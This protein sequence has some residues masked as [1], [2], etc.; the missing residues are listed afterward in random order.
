MNN[1]YLVFVITNVVLAII[2][3]IWFTNLCIRIYYDPDLFYSFL[4]W[5]QFIVSGY[6]LACSLEITIN[7]IIGKL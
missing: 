4:W 3:G 7:A 6:L 5:L 1:K 2:T